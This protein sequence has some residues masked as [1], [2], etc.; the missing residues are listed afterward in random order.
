MSDQDVTAGKLMVTEFEA[1]KRE[2]AARI[3]TRDNLVYAAF[4]AMGLVVAAGLRTASGASLLLLLPPVVV[5]LGWTRVAN[6]VKVTH[7]GQYVRGDLSRRLEAITGEAV[8]GW[9]HAHR[10]DSR[11]RLR[12]VCQTVADLVLFGA[13]PLVALA[14]YWVSAPWNVLLAGLSVLEALLVGG[15]VAVIAV[16]S[17][18]FEQPA[19]DGRP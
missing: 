18:V 14:I 19:R 2:Q 7:I 10:S 9:E 4:A 5:V 11:R 12:M 8:F 16:Y 17:G 13:A 6:D 15:L 1:L 3:G